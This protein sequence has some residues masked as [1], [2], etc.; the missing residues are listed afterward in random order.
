[1]VPRGVVVNAGGC[2]KAGDRSFRLEAECGSET[3]GI[4]SNKFLDETYKTKNYSVDKLSMKMEHSAINRIHSY[5]YLL[6][7]QSF[8]ILIRTHWKKPDPVYLPD[9]CLLVI[10]AG[11]AKV[12]E[13]IL[14][15]TGI[16]C[17]NT[18][19]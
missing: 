3:Y 10:V 18:I 19:P 17:I 8:T 12:S 9:V 13:V 14:F 15:V 16:A 1:M 2:V 11:N 6:T 7:R 5:G 4:M